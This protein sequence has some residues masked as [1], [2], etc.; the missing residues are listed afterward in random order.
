MCPQSEQNGVL[1]VTIVHIV[2]FECFMR[3]AIWKLQND[4][5]FVHCILLNAAVSC[6]TIT[7]GS[8]S[9]LS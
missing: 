6:E 2:S 3:L 5:R 4:D 9:I 7:S 8:V 1:V